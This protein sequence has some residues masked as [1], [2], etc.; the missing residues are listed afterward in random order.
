VHNEPIDSPAQEDQTS[1]IA[2][3]PEPGRDIFAGEPVK[4]IQSEKMSVVETPALEKEISTVII[5][6]TT[7]V[8]EST[9]DGKETSEV[10]SSSEEGEGTESVDS[11]SVGEDTESSGSAEETETVS[12]D[13]P[14]QKPAGPIA[15]ADAEAERAAHELYPDAM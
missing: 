2:G 14:P 15:E 6:P 12:S 7:S 11:A 13:I 10:S 3:K 4:D 9:V 1:A 5:Q 8:S